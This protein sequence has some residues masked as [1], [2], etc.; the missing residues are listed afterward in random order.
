MNED[1]YFVPLFDGVQQLVTTAKESVQQTLSHTDDIPMSG[2]VREFFR[3]ALNE[4]KK[5]RDEYSQCT[6]FMCRAGI[7]YKMQYLGQR[8]LKAWVWTTIKS[9]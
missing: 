6:N 3:V 7:L 2:Y 1:G 9:L 8:V 4:A 5:L